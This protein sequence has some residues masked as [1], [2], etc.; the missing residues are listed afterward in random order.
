MHKIYTLDDVNVEGKRVLLRVDLNVPLK[1]GAILD[2]ERIQKIL[3]TVNELVAKQA[4]VIVCAH[5]GRPKGVDGA[6]SLQPIADALG[7]LIKQKIALVADYHA[8]A[9][10]IARMQGGQVLML[11]NS[12]F[13]IRVKKR[14]TLRLRR[15]L[16]V[17]RTFM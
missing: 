3:P 16:R 13:H 10:T 6:L 8:A 14:M 17:L 11:E 12:R 15:C 1:D 4:K 5:L 7:K 9:A 2:D